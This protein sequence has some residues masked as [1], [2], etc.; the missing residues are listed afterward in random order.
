M[1]YINLIVMIAFLALFMVYQKRALHIFQQNRYEF[2]RYTKW[3]LNFKNYQFGDY[4]MFV[5][6]MAVFDFIAIKF[7]HNDSHLIVILFI[8]T[9]DI[10]LLYNESKKTYIK[11]LVY[12]PRVKR[13]V[14]CLT[15][16][17]LVIVSVMV[18]VFKVDY[19]VI[20]VLIAPLSW[21]LIYLMAIITLPIENAIK[22]KYEN[23]GRDIID[24]MTSLKKIGITGSFGKTS[25]KNIIEN[26]MSDHFYTLMTPASYNTPMGITRTIREYLKP[27]HEV[28]ICEMGADHVGDI[29]YLMNY[30]KPSIGVVTSIG[31][32]HLN[33]FHSLDNIINE[34]MKMIEMLPSDGLGIINIDNEYINN[35][36]IKNDV[37][38]VSCGIKNQDA[39]FVAYDI[40]YN[41][42]GSS[43]KVNV[44]DE[45][46]E[47]KTILLGEHN[48]MNILIGIA[49]AANLGI[50]NEDIIASVSRIKR[51]EHRL[52]LKKINGITFIDN[53]FNSN[54]VGCKLSLDVLK[55]MNERRVIVT[56]GLIDLGAIEGKANYEFGQY[57]KDRADYVL[58][59]G[60]IQTEAIYKGLVDSDFDLENVKVFDTVKEAFN[61]IYMNFNQNDTILL[62]NDLPD[63]FSR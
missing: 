12:T 43:F 6:L 1:T 28:F 11:P 18:Y 35:Y 20:G 2:E 48:I 23:E 61:Y 57:M 56:P 55:M 19:L 45:V 60:K 24:S 14:I 41:V 51:I 50:K 22:K 4:F 15:I 5:A 9:Y 25:T 17:D 36:Q 7:L 37:K 32:Q 42:E 10:Y 47:F 13:Q 3:L 30:V 54:P 46:C 31:P 58:L 21:L 26:I 59:V 38:V 27:I 62:E 16:L 44:N 8:I 40:E 63:A 53:A 34:K 52:E 49:I 29:E 33:T 39:D